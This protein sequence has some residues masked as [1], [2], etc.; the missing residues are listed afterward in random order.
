MP[1]LKRLECSPR[2][3][4]F[5]LFLLQPLDGLPNTGLGELRGLCEF[6]AFCFA[7]GVLALRRGE[8]GLA[9]CQTRLDDGLAV[10]SVLEL[11]PSRLVSPDDPVCAICRLTG[12]PRA[13]YTV[14]RYCHAHLRDDV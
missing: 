9:G 12:T 11:G 7:K 4:A 2:C 13:L 3:V 14:R 5:L 10:L 8:P 1:F 6:F